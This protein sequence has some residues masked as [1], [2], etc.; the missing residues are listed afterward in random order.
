MGA[1]LVWHM[2]HTSPASTAC[3]NSTAPAAS[4]TRTAPAPFSSNVLSCEPYSSAFCA[5]RPTLA[6]AP[7]VAT[8]NCPFF[9]TSLTITS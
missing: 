4:V 3:S 8:L 9:C 7:M 2:R 6:V 1:S 5:M